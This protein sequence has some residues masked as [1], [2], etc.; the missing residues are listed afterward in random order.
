[1]PAGFP[2]FQGILL[3]HAALVFDGS[4]TSHFV[5]EPAALKLYW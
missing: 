5:T 1:M 2:S 3:H 4:L